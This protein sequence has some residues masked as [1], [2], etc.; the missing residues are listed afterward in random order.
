MRMQI[1]NNNK[2]NNVIAKTIRRKSKRSA[3]AASKSENLKLKL[4]KIKKKTTKIYK[5][6]KKNI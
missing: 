3:L 2:I 4:K 6:Y 1:N 5:N